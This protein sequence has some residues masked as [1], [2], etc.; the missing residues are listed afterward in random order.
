V[1]PKVHEFRSVE[2]LDIVLTEWPCGCWHEEGYLLGELEHLRFQACTSC[3]DECAKRLEE[4]TLDKRS[5][6]T[7]SL[8]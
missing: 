2:G 3:F 8:P 1:I 6:L 4:L 7:L 5:Q